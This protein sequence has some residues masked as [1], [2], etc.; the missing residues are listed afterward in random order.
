MLLFAVMC[1][2]G[3][4]THFLK[5]L[6]SARVSGN[7]ISPVQYWKQYPYQSA[8]A[9]IG[10]VVGLIV[11]HEANQLNL[12]SAYGVGFMANSVPDII[13]VRVKGKI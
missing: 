5:A 3:L 6:I 13:G 7:P 2:L 11:L 12:A 1:W 9:I 8:L 4:A 10:A